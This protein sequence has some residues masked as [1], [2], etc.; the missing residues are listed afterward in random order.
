MGEELALGPV[1]ARAP[2]AHPPA[3]GGGE[4]VALLVRDLHIHFFTYAGVVKALNGVGLVLRRGEMSALVGESGAGKSVLAWALLGLTR[5]PGKVVGGEIL[6]RGANVLAMSK[7]RLGAMRGREIALIVSNPRSH[8]HPLKKVGPQIE[9]V[10]RAGNRADR[11]AA[12]P[13]TLAALKAVE[14]PDPPRVYASYPHELSGGMAQRV[15][16]AMALINR[17]ELVIADDATNALDVTVQRQVLDLMTGLIRQQHASALMIT[18]ELGIVAQYCQRA[19]IIYAG[20]VYEVADTKRLFDNPLHPYTQGLLA[21]S[22]RRRSERQAEPLPSIAPDPMALPRGCYLA[23]RCPVALPECRERMPELVE[24]EPDHWVR[25]LRYPARL[26][27]AI[28]ADQVGARIPVLGAAP[29]RASDPQ[30]DQRV[31]G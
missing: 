23:P 1:P 10:Y 19:T 14:M 28:T 15:L 2:R 6:W 17:P 27:A 22:R 20:Q 13:A 11:R 4:D 31:A 29:A 7:E 18:H 30:R 26:A 21:T 3:P 16:I 9:A 25:C 8:L 12:R 5:H 24:V